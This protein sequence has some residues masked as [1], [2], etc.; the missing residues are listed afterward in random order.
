MQ[1]ESA[2]GQAV[3]VGS[4][5]L[6]V[7]RNFTVSQLEN[8]VVQ[9]QHGNV[10]AHIAVRETT[11]AVATDQLPGL[12]QA[13]NPAQPLSAIGG[14]T[15]GEYATPGA[16]LAS[17][18]YQQDTGSIG[19]V[20]GLFLVYVVNGPRPE[21]LVVDVF[22]PGP[23][24]V[25]QDWKT[26][27]EFAGALL[28]NRSSMPSPAAGTRS[29]PAPRETPQP[30]LG[31]TP[32]SEGYIPDPVRTG[33]FSVNVINKAKHDTAEQAANYW[34]KLFPDE[35]LPSHDAG[36]IYATALGKLPPD[37]KH[38]GPLQELLD[39]YNRMIDSFRIGR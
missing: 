6:I 2:D 22:A 10:T 5:R 32:G 20:H 33:D 31:G 21:A 3:V 39:R 18:R 19:V 13:W 14:I 35:P 26:L 37:S 29:Q 25:A 15:S 4:H 7:P 36:D 9:V 8:S 38:R 30:V 27:T 17:Q 11:T 28:R 1:G 24:E 12:M 23:A 34:F 16:T